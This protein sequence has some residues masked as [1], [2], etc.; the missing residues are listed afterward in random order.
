MMTRDGSGSGDISHGGRCLPRASNEAGLGLSGS[1]LAR[2]GLACKVE[3]SRRL[4]AQY[5]W[6]AS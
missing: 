2:P 5:Q 6:L 1:S 4:G 3:R